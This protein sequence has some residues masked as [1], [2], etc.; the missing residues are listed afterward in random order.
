MTSIDYAKIS[1]L[2]RKWSSGDWN[3]KCI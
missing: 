1:E 2:I 3:K